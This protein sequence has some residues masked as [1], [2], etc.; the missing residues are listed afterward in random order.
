VTI[1]FVPA[2]WYKK[3]PRSLGPIRLIVVHSME[4]REMGD[5]AETCANYFATTDR[6]ASAHVCVDSNS[7]VRSVKDSDIAYAAP[8]AN[9]DG[10]HLELAGRAAQTREEWLDPYGQDLLSQAAHQVAEWST[11]WGVP[12]K[13]LSA[14]QVRDG[15]WGVT[16]H[17]A[18]RLAY[19]LTDHTD[20]GEGFPMD[21]LLS[22]SL[23]LLTPEE[24]EVVKLEFVKR[25][26]GDD[27]VY[28]SYSHQYKMR[29]LTWPDLQRTAQLAGIPETVVEMEPSAVNFMVDVVDDPG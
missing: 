24:D 23:A 4:S 2:R 29:L 19:G 9:H 14:Q 26:N 18:V 5:T 20:P 3:G 16:T 11:G 22:R 17:N 6:P 21:E 15:E 8:G 1:P 25:N 27:R 12:L 10:L 13:S 7:R 28:L